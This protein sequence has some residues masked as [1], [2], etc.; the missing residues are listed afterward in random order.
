MTTPQQTQP[1]PTAFTVEDVRA[2]LAT[3]TEPLSTIAVSEACAALH[4]YGVSLAYELRQSTS[5]ALNALA[6][7][8]E[9]VSIREGDG[10]DAKY[11]WVLPYWRNATYRYWLRHDALDAWA[12]ELDRRREVWATANGHAEKLRELFPTADGRR[13]SVTVDPMNRDGKPNDVTIRINADDLALLVA[14]LAE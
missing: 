3:V 2:A 10:R 9:L 5:K 8:G 14:K 13:V 12:A 6:D 11:A 7:T 1:I 4:G